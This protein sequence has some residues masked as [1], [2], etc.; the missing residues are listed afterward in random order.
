MALTK[1]TKTK[2]Y[3]E[4]NCHVFEL[5]GELYARGP[6]GNRKLIPWLSRTKHKYGKTMEYYLVSLI[7]YEEKKQITWTLQQLLYAWFIGEIPKGYDVDHIDGD[8]LNN[9]LTNLQLLSRK[10]NLAK[11]T[12]SRVNRKVYCEELNTTY[13]SITAAMRELGISSWYMM[14]TLNGNNPKKAKYHFTYV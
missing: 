11:R 6:K 1:Q 9:D 4:E 7:D 5:D 14:Q 3:L 13:D 10:D 8:T 12:G 2:K